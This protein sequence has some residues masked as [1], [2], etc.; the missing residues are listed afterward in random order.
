MR[1]LTI[2]LICFL[3]IST[4]LKAY[5]DAFEAQS[6]NTYTIDGQA[7][8]GFWTW[9]EWYDISY[10]WIPYGE[11]VAPNDFSGRFKLAWTEDV[12]LV[13]AEIEDNV[14]S[15]EYSDP[16]SNYWMDD[17]FEVFLDEDH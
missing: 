8:E 12:L 2:L 4:Q 11:T 15:D 5:D 3:S 1:K 6:A 10:V 16:L 7:N 13:L 17:C 9:A 14:L